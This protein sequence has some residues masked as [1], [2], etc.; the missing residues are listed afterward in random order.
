[1]LVPLTAVEARGPYDCCIVGAGPAGITLAL[2]LAARGKRVLLCEGGGYE[3]DDASQAVYRSRVVGDPY[4]DLEFIRLR[5]FGGTSGYWGGVCRPL[6]AIDFEPK[7]H[8]PLAH[9]PIRKPDLDPHL[10]AASAR[11]EIGPIPPDEPVPGSGLQR[12][13]FAYSPPTRFGTAYRAAVVGHANVDLCLEANAI[14]VEADDRRVTGILLGDFADGRA[15]AVASTYVLATGGIENSRLLLWSNEVTGGRLVKTA[16]SLGRYW[17]DHPTFTLGDFVTF[18]RFEGVYFSLTPDRQRELGLLHCGL[19]FHEEADAPVADLVD[20]LA[21]VAP[22]LAHW[23]KGRLPR[24]D[25][26]GG[27]LR[28]AWEQEPRAANRV[29]LSA[30][31]VDRFGVPRTVLHWRKSAEDLVTVQRTA[32]DF[33]RFLA[34][35][36]VGR[37]RLRDWVLGAGDYPDDDELTGNHHMGG[38]RMASS[39]AEG[40]VDADLRVHGQPNLY[41]LGSSVFPSGGH[42]N[43]TL[44]ILQLAHRL[45]EHLTEQ[46]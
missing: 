21:A 18:R 9:W 24:H 41:V 33:A 7:P 42:A 20:D 15:K 16:T 8:H 23:A 2:D 11:V 26:A 30:T 28:A 31:E 38:T 4:R 12:I 19:R 39:P 46:V 45:A 32:L 36:D 44:T 43:P 14:H 25:V 22:A 5:C 34:E 17:M 1:M 37:V 13:H 40:V 3:R 27:I 6:D 29:E 10:A 35:R